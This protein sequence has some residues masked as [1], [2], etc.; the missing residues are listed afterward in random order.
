MNA[1]TTKSDSKEKTI[2]VTLKRSIS[3]RRPK[4][5]LT[6][7]SLGLRRINQSKILKDNAAIRGMLA[8]VDYLLKIEDLA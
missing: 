7:Q 4:H 3:G 8:Q 5:R 2:K 6:I 1:R